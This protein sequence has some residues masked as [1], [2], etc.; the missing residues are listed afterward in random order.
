MVL[1]SLALGIGANTA[2]FSLLHQ[3]VLA[4]LP[5]EKPEEL[6]LITSPGEFKSGRSSTN[7]SGGGDYIFSY[8]DFSRARKSAGC[9]CRPGGIRLIW[10][11]TWHT[12]IRPSTGLQWWYRAPISTCSVLAR[13][14]AGLLTPE[15]DRHG[16]G[17]PVAVLSYGYWK[18][19]LGGEPGVLNQTDSRQRAA[20]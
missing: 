9:A 12:A 4:S 10:A 18:D 8:P 7:D 14:W 16:A 17:N 1:L 5:V 11:R 3:V 6:V 2:I 19:K 15:D 13:S 20:R